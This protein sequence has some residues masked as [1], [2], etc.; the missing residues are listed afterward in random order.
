MSTYLLKESIPKK[1]KPLEI[2]LCIYLFYF[3]TCII[4]LTLCMNL[5]KC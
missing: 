1:L 2:H 3:L 5:S 4:N